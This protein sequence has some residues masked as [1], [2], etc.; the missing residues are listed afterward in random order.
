[1]RTRT[2]V[3][4]LKTSHTKKNTMAMD[5]QLEKLESWIRIMPPLE[6][7]R[8]D[9]FST[10]PSDRKLCI[11]KNAFSSGVWIHELSKECNNTR[12]LALFIAEN[13]ILQLQLYVM[14]PA[15]VG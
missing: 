6:C 4:S 2:E 12:S 14:L 9:K 1:M 10:N 3:L 11:S 8:W 13:N 7:L 15:D 5:T